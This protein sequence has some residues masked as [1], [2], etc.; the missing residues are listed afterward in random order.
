MAS[1]LHSMQ[2]ETEQLTFGEEG[3][4]APISAAIEMVSW[5]RKASITNTLV[6]SVSAIIDDTRLYEQDAQT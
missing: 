6:S 2:P 1:E 3:E 5:S 4:V